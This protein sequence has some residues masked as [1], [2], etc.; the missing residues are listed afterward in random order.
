MHTKRIMK[1]GG[2]SLADAQCFKKVKAIVN[3]HINLNPIIVVSA[4]G[5]DEEGIKITDCLKNIVLDLLEGKDISAKLEAILNRHYKL[6]KNLSLPEDTIKEQVNRLKEILSSIPGD[7]FETRKEALDAV[8]GF[9][10]IL[11]STIMAKFLSDENIS[12]DAAI[13]EEFGIV[14]DENFQDADVL[15]ESLHII[16]A[17]VIAARNLLVFPGYIGITQDGRRTTLGR[18]GSDYT[19]AILGASL[20]RDVDIYTD[21][22]GIYRINPCYLP[23]Q[24]REVGHPMTITEL[25]YEEA[26][27]MASFGSRVLHKKTLAAVQQAVRKGKHIHI[28]IKN[29]FNP[30]HPGT[31]ISSQRQHTG[32]PSGITCLEETQL[33]N[34]YPRSYEESSEIA[35][36]LNNVEDLH[37]VLSSNTWGRTSF[38]FDKDHPVLSQLESKY[39]GHLSRDQVL[40]KIVGDGIGENPK[41]LSRIQNSI[42]SAENPEK[43]GMTVVHKSPQL[44]TDNT[45]E[46]LVKKRGLNDIL[47]ALYKDLFMQDIVTVGLLGMGTVGSGVIHYAK[48]MYSTEKSGFQLNF[49]ISLVRNPNKPRDVDFDGKFT[50]NVD[51]ILDNP[52][53]DIVLELIG[54]IEPARTYVIKALE[55]GKHVVTANKALLAK[56]GTEIFRTADNRHRNIGF[57]ASVCA[58]IPIIDDFLNFPG[59]ADIEG[60]QGIVNGT[61]NYILSRFMEGMPFDEALKLAQDKGFAEADPTMDISGADAAQK[62]SILASI[63][64]NQ[65]IDFHNIPCQGI[66]GLLPIDCAAFKRWNVTVKPLV[67]ASVKDEKIQLYVSPALVSGNHPLASVR[68]ENNALSLYLKGRSEPITKIGKGAGAIPT[69]R[70]VV[71]D[72]LD[73]SRKAR[74]YMVEVPGFYKTKTEREISPGANFE[75]C[76]YIR[77]TVKDDP[78]VMGKIATILGD[79]DLSILRIFQEK[80]IPNGEAH[81]LFELKTSPRK[82]LDLALDIITRFPFV[83][84]C[85]YCMIL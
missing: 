84:R 4:L 77:F 50:D 15:E 36:K 46:F 71:R 10:E 43:Y 82:E 35:G 29:T 27:Q 68:E 54:G 31:D 56:H 17:K 14:T 60:I 25:S 78:G 41:I 57:E 19:A 32:I 2:S 69:A 23:G 11:S 22:D 81:I 61:S 76:W 26:F 73:V 28:F 30:D 12:F 44:L 42:N 70:S 3:N 66:D 34:I 72:V 1:F 48:E 8:M 47:L 24:F 6:L 37:I 7:A 9:G 20:K 45:F 53:V 75:A 38:V 63:L 74:A 83:D 51:E 49:P 16:A 79:F 18:G 67:M 59:L 40:V 58:E 62:L 33:L 85:F 64:F 5:V 55:K 65:P 39:V 13:P 80:D 21:V 52:L